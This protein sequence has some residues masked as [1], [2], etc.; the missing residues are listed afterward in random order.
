MSRRLFT[1]V[2]AIAVSFVLLYYSVA[3]A[4]LRCAHD[5]SD[6]EV[7]LTSGGPV[8]LNLE[9]VGPDYHIELIAGSS[10][11]S[12]LDRLMPQVTRHVNDFLTLQARFGDAAI[13]LWLRAVFDRSRSLGF[14]VGLPPYL[15]LSVLRF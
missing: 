9:C 2:V 14:L 5:D 7:A 11:P 6:Y 3:W 12:E 4:V 1:T 13:D 10:S 15:F 8:H